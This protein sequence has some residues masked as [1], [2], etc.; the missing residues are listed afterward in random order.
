MSQ[1]ICEICKT[2]KECF[3]NDTCDEKGN[4]RIFWLC[5]EHQKKYHELTAKFLEGKE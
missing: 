1:M 4:G 5:V 3:Y 2:E